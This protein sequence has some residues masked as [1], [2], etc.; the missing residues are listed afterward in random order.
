MPGRCASPGVGFRQHEIEVVRPQVLEQLARVG[1]ADRG[2]ALFDREHRHQEVGCDA[3]CNRRADSDTQLQRRRRPLADQAL[4][5]PLA[6][7]KH[8]GRVLVRAAS[9][10]GELELAARSLEE[11]QSERALELSN[12]LAHGR[13]TNSELLCSPR[14]RSLRRGDMKVVEVVVVDHPHTMAS[15]L[16]RR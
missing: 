5:E 11:R 7:A 14:D 16:Q 4:H 9:R 12:L 8:D 1:S 10:V 15:T 13:L 6:R 2:N 3:T